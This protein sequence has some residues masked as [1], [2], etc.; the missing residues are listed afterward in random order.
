[1]VRDRGLHLRYC[2]L[3][4]C[5]GSCCA[6]EFFGRDRAALPWVDRCAVIRGNSVLHIPDVARYSCGIA[7]L[8][9]MLRVLARALHKV[10]NARA[11]SPK[12]VHTHNRYCPLIQVASAFCWFFVHSRGFGVVFQCAPGS[13]EDIAYTSP[14]LPGYSAASAFAE[15]FM[16]GKG[17]AV[18][19]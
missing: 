16:R 19:F 18:V 3:R 5:G 12:D 7:C 6:G 17:F 15:F 8:P 9:E 11:G 14:I 2:L 1:M 13:R 10:F 4:I